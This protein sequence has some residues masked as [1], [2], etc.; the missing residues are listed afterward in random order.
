MITVNPLTYLDE[1]L[2]DWVSPRARRLIHSLLTLSLVILGAWLAAEGDW[3]RAALSL[4][5]SLY[6]ASNRANTGAPGNRFP[7][8][9]QVD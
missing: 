6:A 3:K 4:V 1:L 7:E 2:A 5:A 8:T 9:D